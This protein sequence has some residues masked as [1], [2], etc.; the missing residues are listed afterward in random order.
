M[1]RDIEQETRD[2][3]AVRIRE[4]GEHI[5]SHEARLEEERLSFMDVM[6]PL[7]E[8][9]AAVPGADVPCGAARSTH[10]K[11]EGISNSGIHFMHNCQDHGYDLMDYEY[12]VLPW[13]FI[14]GPQEAAEALSQRLRQERA[15]VAQAQLE[16]AQTALL[17]AQAAVEEA[18][19]A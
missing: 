1:T 9:W 10:W 12:F 11:Y 3:L 2:A 18:M 5:T 16:R 15:E 4:A 7:I 13:E 6:Y 17:R 14:T 19:K 8:A